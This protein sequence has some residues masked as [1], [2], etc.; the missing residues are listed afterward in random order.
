MMYSIGLIYRG[1]IAFILLF[2]SQSPN[3]T[4]KNPS[5]AEMADSE[6]P[7]ARGVPNK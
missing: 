2:Y 3:I 4:V 6:V 5:A 7:A 1:H